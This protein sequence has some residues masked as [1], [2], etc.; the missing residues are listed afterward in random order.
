MVKSP[1]TVIVPK[2]AQK[3]FKKIKAAGLSKKVKQL[4]D[5]L[6]EDPF[7]EYPSYEALRGNLKGFYSRRINIH[8][9]LVYSVDKKN[10]I[11]R[12]LRMWTH[13]E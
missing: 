4:Y 2:Q 5:I 10:R 3:D 11:V 13:Y 12:I 9:R 8:H 1:Y 6:R 7:R